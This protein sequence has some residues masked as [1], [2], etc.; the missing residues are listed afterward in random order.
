MTVLAQL[1]GE[2]SRVSELLW[3]VGV[4]QMVSFLSLRYVACCRMEDLKKSV[5]EAV[6]H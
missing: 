2:N 5:G 6:N 4:C 1:F 3:A